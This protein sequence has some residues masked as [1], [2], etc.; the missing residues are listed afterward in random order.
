VNRTA[1][2]AIMAE[3]S[4]TDADYAT[5]VNHLLAGG[6]LN[7]PD[8]LNNT[9]V[10]DNAGAI[11]NLFGEGDTD[12]FLVSTGDTKDEVAGEVVTTI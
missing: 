6:G 1:L 5:R 4:R 3:W 10:F 11:D 7:D 2:D 12:W 9:T 8:F